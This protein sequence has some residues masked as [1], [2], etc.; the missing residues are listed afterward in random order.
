MHK[1]DLDLPEQVRCESTTP[2][3][4]LGTP[5]F[6]QLPAPLLGVL[7]DYSSARKFFI[8]QKAGEGEADQIGVIFK[9]SASIDEVYQADWC[10][11][12]RVILYQKKI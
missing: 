3:K 9:A 12:L 4:G 5:K 8:S 6:L 1:L 11:C 10:H 2:E 7:W